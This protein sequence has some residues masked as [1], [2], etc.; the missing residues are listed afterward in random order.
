MAVWTVD[1]WKVKPGREAHFLKHCEGLSP[2]KLV[3]F[4]DLD[5]QGLFWSPE[6]WESR[7]SLESWRKGDLFRSA[8]AQVEEDVSEHS[9]HLMEEVPGFS[10][11][12]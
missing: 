5:Q 4:R 2:V 10:A 8:A 6:K 1:T 11:R 12:R 3:L 7:E 9:T